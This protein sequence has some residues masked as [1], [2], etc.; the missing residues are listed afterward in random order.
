MLPRVSAALAQ[1]IAPISVST[2]QVTSNK[3]AGDHPAFQ[4]FGKKKRK[5]DGEAS[6]GEA[7]TDDDQSQD[8]HKETALAKVIPL[9]SHSP[10]A[11]QPAGI[12]Y[13]LL[14]LM[15]LLQTQRATVMRWLASTSYQISARQQKKTGKCRKG[16]IL[17][18]KA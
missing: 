15:N 3:T 14:Q 6:A 18:H 17:D 8:D 13:A 12:T 11:D 10:P 1:F 2:K 5:K 7:S 9:R 16:T 4:R